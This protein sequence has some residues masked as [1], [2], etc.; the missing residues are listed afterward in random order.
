MVG[1]DPTTSAEVSR[2]QA[3]CSFFTANAARATTTM[4]TSSFFMAVTLG[5]TPHAVPLRPGCDHE[6]GAVPV[7]QRLMATTRQ[8]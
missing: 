2:I 8:A 3:S 7:A 1:P 4:S 5:R 6:G